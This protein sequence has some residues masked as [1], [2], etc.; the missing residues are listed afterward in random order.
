MVALCAVSACK[1]DA[2]IAGPDP[3]VETEVFTGVIHP[4][5]ASMHPFTVSYGFATTN[6][7][8]IVTKLTTVKDGIPAPVTL[9][10]GF[11]NLSTQGNC[12]RVAHLSNGAA[13]FN[14]E[15]FV[16]N[17]TFAPG[18]YCFEVYD[19]PTTPTVT[20]PLNYSITVKHF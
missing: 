5:G 6:A 4:A 9:G 16:P 10:M 8:A 17:D 20:E 11:G 19:N 14:Q 15:M 18:T 1:K 3:V 7:S 2:P 12:L 13:P